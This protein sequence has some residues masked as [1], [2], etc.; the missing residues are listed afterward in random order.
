[1]R[2][3]DPTQPFLCLAW[4]CDVPGR[5]S[6]GP[7]RAG[8]AAA[9]TASA[10]RPAAS[11]RPCAREPAATA[12]RRA[13][14]ASG[15]SRKASPACLVGSRHSSRMGSL[16]NRV[17]RQP[18]PRRPLPCRR[19]GQRPCSCRVAGTGARIAP[20][21]AFETPAGGPDARRAPARPR[22]KG[23]NRA[24]GQRLRSLRSS[25]CAVRERR[26]SADH[27]RARAGTGGKAV[28]GISRVHERTKKGISQVYETPVT[29][30]RFFLSGT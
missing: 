26:R 7:S 10:S 1:V 11:G 4:T 19:T 28:P 13:D 17:T 25:G 8:R 12:A 30:G 18:G 15:P 9:R 16:G 22:R 2:L 3:P 5:F 24:R 20:Q 27:R 14:S 23:R 21:G 29:N 6:A